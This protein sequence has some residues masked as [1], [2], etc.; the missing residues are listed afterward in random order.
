M[1]SRFISL[2]VGGGY[3]CLKWLLREIWNLA[4]TISFDI[5]IFQN[6]SAPDVSWAIKAWGL[7]SLAINNSI[8]ILL[9]P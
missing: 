8:T 2:L 7:L 9:L 3:I 6:K 4:S 1:Q 5:W